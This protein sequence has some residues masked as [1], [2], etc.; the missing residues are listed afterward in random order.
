[1]HGYPSTWTNLHNLNLIEGGQ[2]MVEGN[3]NDI[4]VICQN[5]KNAMI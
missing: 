5:E 4:Y 2:Y 3:I 1:V